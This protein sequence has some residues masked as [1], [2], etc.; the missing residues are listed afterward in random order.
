MLKPAEFF[1]KGVEGSRIRYGGKS[2]PVVEIFKIA[3]KSMYAYGVE[4]G[5]GRIIFLYL[6]SGLLT[7]QERGSF[8]EIEV[9][10]HEAPSG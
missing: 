1:S 4:E 6:R 8:G 9:V 10:Q 7:D 5:T 3:R 2:A